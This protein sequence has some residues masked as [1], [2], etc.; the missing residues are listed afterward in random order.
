[1]LN[2]FIQ[3]TGYNR[4]YAA[5]VLR[6][7]KVLGYLTINDKRVKYTLSGQKR[8]KQ[9]YYDQDVLLALNQLWEE[10]D[11]ICSKRLAPFLAEFIPV[12]EKYGEINLTR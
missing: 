3:I 10:A 2:E 9:K 11:S 4:S 1:M 6:K 7:K 12:L 8:K 5:R